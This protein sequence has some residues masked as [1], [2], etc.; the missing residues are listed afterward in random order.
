MGQKIT[1]H[2][3]LDAPGTLGNVE[4][5]TF[6][7]SLNPGLGGLGQ[8]PSPVHPFPSPIG[9][10]VKKTRNKCL[11]QNS[12]FSGAVESALWPGQKSPVPEQGPAP[13]EKQQQYGKRE[14]VFD[15]IKC[16]QE[17]FPCLGI[18]GHSEG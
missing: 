16:A 11:L 7:P 18:L 1:H 14:A 2:P 9:C 10:Q 4:S 8:T 13:Y 5:L 12:V 6:V 3:G 17:P 15:K